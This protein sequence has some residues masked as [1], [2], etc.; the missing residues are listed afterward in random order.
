M[1]LG[2]SVA[3]GGV[4]VSSRRS[5]LSLSPASQPLSGAL[6]MNK[7]IQKKLQLEVKEFD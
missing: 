5:S 1:F 3:A 4:A 7:Y 6:F 2:N